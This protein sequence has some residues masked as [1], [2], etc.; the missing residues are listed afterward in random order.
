VPQTYREMLWRL[1]QYDGRRC[2]WRVAVG[3]LILAAIPAMP[4]AA[5]VAD[6]Y[7]AGRAPWPAVAAVGVA[8]AVLTVL[9]GSLWRR[10]PWLA[11]VTRRLWTYECLDALPWA[12]RVLVRP[13][14]DLAAAAALRRAKFN[15]Q[16]FLQVGSAPPDAPDLLVQ[17]HVVRPPAWHAPASDAA[18]VEDVADVFRHA[19]IRARVAGVDVFAR[20]G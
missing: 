1:R 15:P 14:D 2:L 5:I 17:I 10:R 6:T 4:A 18:Q 7:L 13:G 9:A 12:V 19:G 16:S 3:G 8:V 11:P 20:N